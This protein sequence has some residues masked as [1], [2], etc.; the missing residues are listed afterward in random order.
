MIKTASSVR[1]FFKPLINGYLSPRLI[2][3]VCGNGN[4]SLLIPTMQRKGENEE[5]KSGRKKER[6]KEKGK[7]FPSVLSAKAGALYR[8]QVRRCSVLHVN[9]M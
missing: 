1:Y 7:G 5:K 2:F 9:E 6:V 4:I 8:A 3:I